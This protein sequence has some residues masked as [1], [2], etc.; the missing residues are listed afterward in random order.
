MIQHIMERV[1]S[2]YVTFIT[3]CYKVSLKIFGYKYWLNLILLWFIFL[4][5]IV[6]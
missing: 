4:A 6:L 1:A 2:F 5:Y 3:C